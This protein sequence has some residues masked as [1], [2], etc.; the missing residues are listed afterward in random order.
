M[1]IVE[2]FKALDNVSQTARKHGRS[3]T[4]VSDII[5]AAG[6]SAS[7]RQQTKDATAALVVEGR[8]RRARIADKWRRI[9]EQALD[10]CIDQP[11]GAEG[12]EAQYR[13]VRATG[14]GRVIDQ[15]VSMMPSD[16]F[17]NV[18][19]GAA[20]A[21]DKAAKLE[22]LDGGGSEGKGLLE[23]LVQ[24]IEQTTT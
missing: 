23:S 2:T 9:E 11:S 5:K 20:I 21:S 18:M 7:G 4:A 22:A 1:A 6:L 14:S 16:D 15:L 8:A 19:T 12:E 3:K 10:R 24:S 13:L 17:R